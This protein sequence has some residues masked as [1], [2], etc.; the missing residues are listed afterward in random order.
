MASPATLWTNARLAA[1]NDAM[2]QLADAALLTRD[3]KIAW[4]G[5]SHAVPANPGPIAQTFDLEGRWITPGLIDC[6]THLVFC[7]TRAAEFAERQRGVS[8]EQVAAVAFSR[9]SAPRAP[10]VR[11]SSSMRARRDSRRCSPRASR[12]SR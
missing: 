3:G 12:R 2:S 5:A 6:H 7:G 8:Y 9:P 10:R 1:C 4:V 11:R